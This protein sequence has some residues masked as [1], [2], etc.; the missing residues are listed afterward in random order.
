MGTVEVD[1]VYSDV[2]V[3]AIRKQNGTLRNFPASANTNVAAGVALVAAV[4]AYVS[5][6]TIDV[7]R[8]AT[9]TSNL[10]R[11]GLT[12]NVPL[13]VT[14]THN[15]TVDGSMFDDLGSAITFTVGGQGSFVRDVTG[16]VPTGSNNCGVLSIANAASKVSFTFDT[17]KLTYIGTF[18]R[19]SA[20]LNAVYTQHG[21][22]RM[23]GSLLL[24]A[25]DPTDSVPTN[26]CQGIYWRNGEFN[27][28]I[29]QILYTG[30]ID[31]SGS[32]YSGPSAYCLYGE[33]TDST[34]GTFRLDCLTIQIVP[35]QTQAIP[36]AGTVGAVGIDDDDPASATWIT[37]QTIYGGVYNIGG[38]LYVTTQKLFGTFWQGPQD[39]NSE[40]YLTIQ[41]IGGACTTPNT[42]VL[43][44][45]AGSNPFTSYLNV[46]IDKFDPATNWGT[47]ITNTGTT[48]DFNGKAV[49]G[50]ASQDAFHCSKG[51]INF[52]S[53]VITTGSSQ[54][55]LVQT[56]T[57][58]INVTASAVYDGTKTT[59]SITHLKTFGS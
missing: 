23:Q 56:N 6:D 58:A 41:K 33:R 15:G 24:I 11:D 18:T 45:Q 2:A 7:Y 12:I 36:P 4:N 53:G 39:A 13:G 26:D 52:L 25:P 30:F 51:T 59:G 3:C 43:F 17:I 9:V 32:G 48:V 46:T 10:A 40:T 35:S 21:N 29:D 38:K 50:A 31:S 47:L 14:I 34:T 22:V 28:R 49:T 16:L 27:G 5:G 42:P 55:D 19:G 37:A 57:G 1:P 20:T 44:P 8:S 54:K